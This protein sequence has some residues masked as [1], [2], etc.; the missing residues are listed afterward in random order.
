M[1]D[2]MFWPLAIKAMAEHLKSLHMDDNGNTP[3]LI[4]FGVNLDLIPVKNFHTLFCP[5]Y[6]LDHCLQSAGGPGPPKWE[7]RSR[8]GVYLGHS[9]FHVGSMALVFNPKTAKISPQYHVVFD[10]DFTNVPYME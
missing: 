3:E 2:T 9:P 4:M 1:V 7:P 6:V 5:L 8:I 10:N